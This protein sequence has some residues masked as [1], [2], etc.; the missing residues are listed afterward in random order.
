MNRKMVVALVLLLALLGAGAIALYYYYQGVYYAITDDARV[1]APTVTVTP[2][3]PGK[4]IS[5]SVREG[6]K[7]REGQVLGRQDLGSVMSAGAVNP[8]ALAS[9]SPVLAEKAEIRAPIGGQVIHSRVVGE[10]AALGLPLAIIAD[11]GDLHISA[12]TKENQIARVRP[13][14]ELEVWLDAYPR[15]VFRGRVTSI[16]GATASVFS[17]LPSQ[18]ATGTCTKVTQVVPVRIDLLEA[19]DVELMPGMNAKVKIHLR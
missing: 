7:V 3:I 15:R 16:S 10:M 11:T 9:A 12:N 2:E 17:L 18:N 5:W 14:Q 6:D 1:A 19:Q 4:I 13:G 8:Q